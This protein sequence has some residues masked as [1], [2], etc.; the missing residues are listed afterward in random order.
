MTRKESG[1]P[2]P[3]TCKPHPCNMPQAKTEVALQFSERCA[4]ETALQHWLFCSFQSHSDQKLRCNKR[5]AALQHRKS[6]VGGK[7]RFPCRF[8]A[9]FKPPR[10]GTHVSD[11]LKE[12]GPQKTGPGSQKR[13]REFCATFGVLQEGSAAIKNQLK[14]GFAEPQ[15]VLHNFGSPAQLFRPCKFSS[16]QGISAMGVFFARFSRR[17]LAM[18]DRKEIA[19]GHPP[20]L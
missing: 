17:S 6:C 18:F 5:K 1:S 11:L 10:L 16:Q 20:F 8:P 12:A 15:K 2:K 7:W 14:K 3:H 9:A 13:F 19:S 4:A